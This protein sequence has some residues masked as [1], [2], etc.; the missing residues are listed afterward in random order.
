MNGYIYRVV[1]SNAC[2]PA[3]NSSSAT[4]T[5]TPP[6]TITAHPA[7]STICAGANTTFTFAAT[8][9]TSVR[10]QV[11][12]GSGFADVPNVAPY[13]GVTTTTLTITGAT[14]AMNG[15]Q[16]RGVATNCGGDANSNAATLTISIPVSFT[17]QPASQTVCQGATVTFTAVTTGTVSSYQWQFSSDGG[18]TYNNI[19]GATTTSYT[20]NPAMVG[21][22]NYRFRL[23]ATG[24]CG[25]V[26]S[27][28]ATLTVNALPVFT[29][30][31]IPS[32]VCL[33][34]PPFTLTA[35]VAG[36]TWT[37]AGVSGS[38]FTPAAAGLGLKTITYSVTTAGCTTAM[39]ANID[40]NECAGRHL[41]L[42]Q[43]PAIYITP[44]PNNGAFNVR[45]NTD[46][47]SKLSLRVFTSSGSLV[48]SVEFPTVAFGSVLPVNLGDVPNGTYHLYLTN[49][50]HGFI[51]R[52]S[53]IVVVHK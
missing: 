31:A 7:N 33:S 10:W 44:N 47:Y 26:N 16:Y 15:Y 42:N 17:T 32:V 30:G 13:S 36:G 48:K 29:L 22:N 37:G 38:T 40:V 34:D 39:I 27:N 8:G 14:A 20:I 19:A 5:V 35:S 18:T 4:L 50:E 2:T 12:T 1:V 3:A 25:P 49:D 53:S 41:L 51:S 28:A 24:S 45:V 52:G 46:L 6:P 11:N 21:Q 43:Y 9:A 23:V